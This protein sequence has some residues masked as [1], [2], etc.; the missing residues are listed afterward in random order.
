[1]KV[2]SGTTIDTNTVPMG[3]NPTPSKEYE[4]QKFNK[5]GT[6]VQPKNG[7]RKRHKYSTNTPETGNKIILPHNV[8]NSNP[9]R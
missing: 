7:L 8:T 2:V 1:M 9:F 4:D 6:F 3:N 5:S